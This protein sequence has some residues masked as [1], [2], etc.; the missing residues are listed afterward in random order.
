TG[1]GRTTSGRR[2]MMFGKRIWT[3]LGSLAL[4][5]LA[6]G[7][8]SR[9]EYDRV[10]FARKTAVSHGDEL[11]REV[12]DQRAQRDVIEA[13]RNALRRERDTKA[14]M[15]ENMQAEIR[16]LDDTLKKTQGFADSALAAQL[17]E[18]D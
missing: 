12:A 5:A 18:P 14:A 10:E 13:D 6:S 8:V 1:A 3:G 4:L 17:K 11:E 7:C 9:A 2:Q 16:R 15:V